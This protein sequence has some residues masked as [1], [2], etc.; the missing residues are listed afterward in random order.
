M[1]R[2]QTAAITK[3]CLIFC[4]GID[5]YFFLIYW[6][7]SKALANEEGFSRDIQVVNFGGNS[8][9]SDTLQSYRLVENFSSVTHLMIIRDAEQDSHAATQSIQSALHSA[10]LT[11]PDSPAKWCFDSANEIHIGFLLFPQLT[12]QPVSGTLE[13]LCVQILAGNDA[14]DYLAEITPFLQNI[15]ACH[16]SFTHPHKTKLH[17]YFSVSDKF[18]GL[19]IG[20]SAKA[21]AFDWDNP[22]LD[23]LKDFVRCMLTTSTE[24]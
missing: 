13:D 9:L 24:R 14:H 17:T 22:K 23:P 10:G 5:E 12:A 11:A 3:K 19:K 1:S 16:G 15:S 7:N 18:T 20:E 4:E 8:D 2:P 6:L 21:G